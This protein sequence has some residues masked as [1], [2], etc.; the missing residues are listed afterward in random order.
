MAHAPR[1]RTGPPRRP[2]N[3]SHS[4]IFGEAGEETLEMAHAA[5]TFLYRRRRVLGLDEQTATGLNVLC[6]G[7][8]AEL[9]D[10]AASTA[11][12]ADSPA[13]EP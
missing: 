6:A 7:I 4:A 11:Q 8:T 12:V 10:R 1:T 9:E 13:G 5:A 3:V 2:K